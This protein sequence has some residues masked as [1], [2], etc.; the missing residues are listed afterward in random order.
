MQLGKMPGNE[1]CGF[2]FAFG[3]DHQR[4][5]YGHFLGLGERGFRLGSGLAAHRLY[6]RTGSE[7]GQRHG[8]T[9]TPCFESLSGL[10]AIS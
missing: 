6:R 10:G 8:A 7:D 9:V 4:G 2:D 3:W 5:A 1:H